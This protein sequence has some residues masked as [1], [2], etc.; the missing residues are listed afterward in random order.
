MNATPHAICLHEQP[1]AREEKDLRVAAD[2]S[3]TDSVVPIRDE[4]TQGTLESECRPAWE[5]PTQTIAHA[6][7]TPHAQTE[8]TELSQEHRHTACLFTHVV[9]PDLDSAQI[10]WKHVAFL[11]EGASR[12]ITCLNALSNWRWN[13]KIANAWQLTEL[14][15]WPIHQESNT[16]ATQTP[17]TAVSQ[18][19]TCHSFESATLSAAANNKRVQRCARLNCHQR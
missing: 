17:T 12:K 18:V 15:R 7:S 4:T 1:V 9:W 10:S 6:M 2:C 3:N 8:K 5:N 11:A 19:R 14:Q 13:H 16:K